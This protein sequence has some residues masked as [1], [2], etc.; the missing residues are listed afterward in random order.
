M[1]PLHQ[2]LHPCQSRQCIQQNGRRSERGARVCDEA[3]FLVCVI[4]GSSDPV[5][6]ASH[7]S[8]SEFHAEKAVQKRC[9]PVRMHGTHSP[10]EYMYICSCLPGFQASADH[11]WTTR[12]ASLAACALGRLHHW[13]TLTYN[14]V[15]LHNSTCVI[16]LTPLPS[17]TL[18]C[19]CLQK[20]C[21]CP[22]L[23]T[24]CYPL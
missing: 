12:S 23:H 6:P 24:L 3:V 15:R 17:C 13:L 5:A 7:A 21:V 20:T 19:A 18:A 1:A 22:Y 10:G 4:S 11:N 14:N 9:V 2:L 16:P 8:A